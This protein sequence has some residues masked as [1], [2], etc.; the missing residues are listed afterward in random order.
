MYSITG[1]VKLPDVNEYIKAMA[2]GGAKFLVFA[3]HKDVL[4]G[5]AQ[6]L[7]ENDFAYIRIDGSTGMGERARQV[8]SFQNEDRV[9]VAVLG[10][11]A[12]GVGLTLTAANAVVFAELPWVPGQIL[13]VSA[14]GCVCV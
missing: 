10:L 1:R 13:Q 5:I 6:A 11:T 3:H 4:N 8:E 7:D 2:E 9:Q 14:H 12:A